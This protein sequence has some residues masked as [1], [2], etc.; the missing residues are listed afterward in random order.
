MP[1]R[2]LAAL[3]SHDGTQWSDQL[4]L[5]SDGK[6]YRTWYSPD[7]VSWAP[8]DLPD[9][10]PP[11]P[12]GLT[13]TNLGQ[14]VRTIN[15]SWTAVP[16]AESYVLRSQYWALTTG[17]T[18]YNTIGLGENTSVSM[19]VH[20]VK[21]GIESGPSN[22]YTVISGF[23]EKAIAAG[24]G[25]FGAGVN[26]VNRWRQNQW[27]YGGSNEGYIGWYS[28]EAYRYHAFIEIAPWY[29]RNLIAQNSPAVAGYER[30]CT[31]TAAG[32]FFTRNG[33]VGDWGSDLTIQ[34]SLGNGIAYANT[35]EPPQQ[36]NVFDFVMK[37]TGSGQV[38]YS[39][40]P[41]WFTAI[42]Q[43]HASYNGLL[44]RPYRNDGGRQPYSAFNAAG[45]I[46]DMTYTWPRIVTQNATMT[47]KG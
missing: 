37:G 28:T 15:M 34:V 30:N 6:L 21:G 19:N 31:A 8:D 22:T 33:S 47:R 3:R 16:G 46:F 17:S 14:T 20:A 27:G 4:L 40:P 41:N 5:G 10:A 25:Y 7:A 45:V 1:T 43:D 26:S 2:R 32:I 38:G 35:N 36:G 11:A 13:C 42:F 12:T 23:E 29:I 44:F 24:S 39:M 9:L 18:S